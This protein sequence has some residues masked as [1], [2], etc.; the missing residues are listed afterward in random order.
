MATR[1]E[2]KLKQVWKKLWYPPYSGL[3]KT[4]PAK[5]L[6]VFQLFANDAI[7][8][9][10]SMVCG[11]SF[12]RKSSSCSYSCSNCSLLLPRK[13]T[14]FRSD[15][16]ALALSIC[17]QDVHFSWP[18]N[19]HWGLFNSG[20]F[21]RPKREWND[22]WKENTNRKR[23]LFNES[24][25]S[26]DFPSTDLYF[27][28]VVVDCYLVPRF[29]IAMGPS[30]PS[31]KTRVLMLVVC[32][33]CTNGSTTRVDICLDPNWEPPVSFMNQEEY[34]RVDCEDLSKMDLFSYFPTS[35]PSE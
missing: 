15:F 16:V 4:R 17:I 20:T 23:K 33:L 30:F 8:K 21:P 19:T 24:A 12:A 6:I 22:S 25:H 32:S 10:L 2:R 27:L 14:T 11:S 31:F 5:H 34:L 13:T 1:Q 29:M 9:K 7:S 18:T 3:T 26:F 35:F 28:W